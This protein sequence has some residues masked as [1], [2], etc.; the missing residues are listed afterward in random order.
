[1]ELKHMKNNLT[2]DYK[3]PKLHVYFYTLNM[4]QMDYL[5]RKMLIKMLFLKSSLM[6]YLLPMY[7]EY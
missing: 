6:T 2:I 3:S 4:L 1:M 5:I 7:S